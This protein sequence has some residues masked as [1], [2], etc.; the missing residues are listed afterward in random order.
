MFEYLVNYGLNNHVS[1]YEDLDVND[2]LML[3]EQINQ[4]RKR[5]YELLQ[6]LDEVNEKIITN[7]KQLSIKSKEIIEKSKEEGI[8]TNELFQ[9]DEDYI[10]IEAEHNA[11][12]AGIQMIYNQI[13]YYKNDLRILNSVF[14]NKF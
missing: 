10:S 1:D 4:V 7:E 11:L 12:K 6:L 13:E 8:R 2:R 14:Y 9:T 3:Q 5:Y